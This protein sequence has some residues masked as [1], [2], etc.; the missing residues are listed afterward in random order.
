MEFFIFTSVRGEKAEPALPPPSL[1]TDNLS[2]LVS[3][4]RS[5]GCTDG[6]IPVTFVGKAF[7]PPGYQNTGYHFIKAIIYRLLFLNA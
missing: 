6:V 4:V 7:P 3:C 5:A 2:P 1:L